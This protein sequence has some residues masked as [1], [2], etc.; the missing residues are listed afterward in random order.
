MDQIVDSSSTVHGHVF[1]E[2]ESHYQRAPGLS[3]VFHSA[4]EKLTVW[5]NTIRL[6]VLWKTLFPQ[7]KTQSLIEND[8]QLQ[9]HNYTKNVFLAGCD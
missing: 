8:Y 2:N 3:S 1:I 6:N 7:H 5:Y 9:L 4:V